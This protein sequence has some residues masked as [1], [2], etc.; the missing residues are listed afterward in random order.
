MLV[1]GQPT[2]HILSDKK[3]ASR[4]YALLCYPLFNLR[5]MMYFSY[6]P[7]IKS[8][9]ITIFGRVDYNSNSLVI[10]FE[11]LSSIRIIIKFVLAPM[12]K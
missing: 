11:K 4:D 2:R 6:Q 10:F 1:R 9:F 8:A 12:M 7:N 3:S 5:P